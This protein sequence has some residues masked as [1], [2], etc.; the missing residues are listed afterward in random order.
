VHTTAPQETLQRLDAEID[1][2]APYLGGYPPQL[3]DDAE[4][5]RVTAQWRRAVTQCG[6]L[7]QQYP[8]DAA[9]TWRAGVLS[10]MGH[11]LDIQGAWQQAERHFKRTLALNPKS[12]DAHLSLGFLY[13]HT[14]PK[15]AL[16]AE[17]AFTRA[18]ALAKDTPLPDA[19]F[20]LTFA[21]Y[22]QA[23]FRDAVREAEVYLALHPDAAAM[24][25]LRDLALERANKA[26]Q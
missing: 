15:Y 6:T 2:L 25:D 8:D 12:V 17:R 1:G 22:Y 14:H 10:Q 9:L 21:Y 20:G 19:H 23:K 3:Q 5:Q 16:P 11:N 26:G 24:K 18:L 7:L 13:V 4:R